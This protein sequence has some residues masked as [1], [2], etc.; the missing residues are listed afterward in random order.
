MKRNSNGRAD[1]VPLSAIRHILS[2]ID[3]GERW[4][5]KQVIYAEIRRVHRHGVI[6]ERA[7]HTK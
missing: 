5:I 3:G 6:S 4:E 7:R 2:A 1:T